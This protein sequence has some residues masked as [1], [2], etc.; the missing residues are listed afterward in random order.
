MK[1]VSD[2]MTADIIRLSPTNKIKTAIIL[3]K[4]H[5]IGGLPVLEDDQVVG[6]L[7]YHDVLGK[8]NDILVQNIMDREFVTIPP[9]MPVSDAANLMSRTGSSRLL[10]M[11][12]THL[13]GV[14]T[15]GDLL[16]EL[17][18]S[19]DPI[20][21]LPRADAMRDWG[22]EALKRGHEITVIFVD[23]DQFGQYNKKYGHITGDKVLKHVARTL[24]DSVDE[25][26]DMLCRYA[27]DEFVIVTTRDREEA[28]DLAETVGDR[29]NMLEYPELPEAVTGSIGL[30]GGKRSREREHVH[31][32]ATLDNLINLASRSCTMAKGTGGTIT[33]LNGV[34]TDHAAVARSF[35]SV[36]EPRPEQIT[37]PKA[38]PLPEMRAESI[39]ELPTEPLPEVKADPQPE[40][41]TE[42]SMEPPTE[43]LP[44][45]KADPQPEMKTEP[46][47]ELPT[48]PLPEIQADP[49]P[50]IKAEPV[51]SRL[52]SQGDPIS[53][54]RHKRLGIQSLNLSWSNS[55]T[56]TAE[57]ELAKGDVACRHSRSGFALGN[58]SLRLV[59]EATAGAVTELLGAPNCGVVL[60]SVSVIHGCTNED[61]VLVTALMITPQYQM[62]VSG[63]AIVKQDV[64]RAAAA[65]LLNAVNRQVSTLI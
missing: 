10:V 37:E 61:V 58:N 25:E 54:G 65:A 47:M 44:E 60:E 14:V 63:S 50:E 7:D 57:V 41:K 48:E 15:R 18:K 53:T 9:D 26:Q 19:F 43:P 22:I 30:H 52:I 5:N 13:A 40:T 33:L 34:P 64:Y 28:K 6:V 32:E 2:V 27:G 45:V 46:S 55:S 12:D 31:Y 56:A 51:P 59:A 42:P 1:T 24:Q 21:G 49:Q 11:K 38:E 8:D 17:G 29:L 62:R 35:E 20:T 3:M 23:L 36:S 4:G 39:T 16:P